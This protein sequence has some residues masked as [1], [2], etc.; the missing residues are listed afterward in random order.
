[1]KNC[2]EPG[3]RMTVVAPSGG[4]TSGVPKVVGNMFVVPITTQASGVNTATMITG[5]ITMPAVS[6]ASTSIAQGGIVYFDAANTQAT[7]SATSNRIIGSME[8]AKANADNVVTV[9]LDGVVR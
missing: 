2:V 7:N 6:G 1:M 5:V 3:L 4:L 9:R 8:V